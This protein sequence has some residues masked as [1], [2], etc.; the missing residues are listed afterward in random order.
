[1][2]CILLLLQITNPSATQRWE[3][4]KGFQETRFA[5][6]RD[7]QACLSELGM[8]KVREEKSKTPKARPYTPV[9]TSK[10][11]PSPTTPP[12]PPAPAKPN[13][14]VSPKLEGL[15][16]SEKALIQRDKESQKKTA[17]SSSTDPYGPFL[18]PASASTSKAPLTNPS[19]SSSK[20]EV[21]VSF[22]PP[23]SNT[24]HPNHYH[25]EKTDGNL[26][27]KDK[28]G[29]TL[30]STT[31]TQK[32]ESALKTPINRTQ[33]D[34][35]TIVVPNDKGGKSTIRVHP[36]AKTW[37]GLTPWSKPR[38]AVTETDAKGNKTKKETDWKGDLEVT[39]TPEQA[40]LDKT[41]ETATKNQESLT[42]W[43][44]QL[45]TAKKGTNTAEIARLKLRVKEA[46]SINEAS[47]KALQ[48][49]QDALNPKAK[50]K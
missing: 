34:W 9:P 26:I 28:E 47:Q 5:N 21:G 18:P 1:V 29:N 2:K 46:T 49:A 20:A 7:E 40:N 13:P 4:E 43:K 12:S 27:L 8:K 15:T 25:F 41:K 32:N 33:G 45:E 35:N 10:P 6:T 50:K 23:S 38:V 30:Y 11:M 22:P 19:A 31:A 16:A 3:A 42:Q 36:D 37:K 48:K 24:E 14:K 17:S 44:D 39:L